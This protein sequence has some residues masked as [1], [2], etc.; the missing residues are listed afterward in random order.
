MP[1]LNWNE[2]KRRAIVFAGNWA[3]ATRER[4]DAQTFWNE[5]FDCFGIRRASVASFE[6]PIRNLGGHTDFIDL[7]WKGKLLA[8]HKSRGK[9]LDRAQSQAND[10]IQSLQREGHGDEVPR[11]LV[12]SD[13]ARVALTDL[14]PPPGKR[15]AFVEFDLKDFPKHVRDFSFLIDIATVDDAPEDDANFQ[16]TRMMATLH[17]ALQDG[18]YAGHDLERLLVRILFC[19]FADDTGIFADDPAAKPF[20]HYIRTH[21]REDGSDLGPQ[22]LRL[23]EV[24]DHPREKRQANLDEDLAR[25]PHVNGQLFAERLS[26]ADFTKP[27]RDTLL[28]C[29]HFDWSKISPAV[30][31]SLFQDV[32]KPRDRRQLGAHYTSER[33]ILKL[34]RSLFLDDLRTELEHLQGLQRDRAKRLHEFQDK[35]RGLTFLD[36]ACGCGNFLVIAYR[37]LRLLELDALKTL[38]VDEPQ[39]LLV[40]SDLVRVNVDQFYGIEIEEWPARIAEVAMWLMDHQMNT[41]VADE[42]ALPL[43]RLPLVASATVRHDNALRVDWGAVLPADRCSYVMGNPPFVGKKEQN[44]AQKAD[45]AHVWGDASGAGVLDLVTCWYLLASRYCRARRVRFAFV[46]TNSICQGEQVGILWRDLISRGGLEITFAH[47]TFAW[48]S[49][50]RGQAHVHVVIIGLAGAGTYAGVRQLY[51][52]RD[53]AEPIVTVVPQISCY[54]TA[55]TSP[56]IVNRQTPLN[57]PAALSYGSFALDDGQYTLTPDDRHQIVAESPPAAMFIH[58]FVGARELLHG[59]DRY[60][61]WLADAAPSEIRALPPVMRRV[62][63]VKQWRQSRGRA[64][65]VGLAETPAIFAEMRQP[66]TQYV[67]I[68]TVSSERRSYIPMDFLSPQVVASNQIYVLAGA[69]LF[70]FGVLTS[71]MHMAWVR[72]VCGRLKS[73]YR[74]SSKLVYNN[75]PWPP[76]ATAAQ[77]QAVEAA[78]QGVLDARSAFPGQTLADLY[79][80]LAMPKALR[81]AHRALDRAVDRCYRPEKFDTDR[82]RVEFLFG[83]YEKLTTLFPAPATRPAKGRRKGWAGGD[84]PA[85]A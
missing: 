74:Y 62:E 15:T 45:F 85:V 58:R 8:E 6:V 66:A 60:C 42:F 20:E 5:F 84:G 68:P 64:T 16:A 76:D 12:V 22:L 44:A 3:K 49:E 30:F 47:T 34:I 28:A 35:L 78:A 10:Y 2:I 41:L 19:L 1:Q 75:Y 27:M 37:E 83:L 23:F 7:F 4:S 53:D 69:G 40:L 25:L 39:R 21:T 72:Q 71:V 59:E 56:F 82:Q 65:T 63:A 38:R 51:E 52:H 33:D 61:L 13:F 54:L 67:A 24:L 57:A 31:G 55:G 50:A 32:M 70:H 43:L 77:R 18:G 9:P 29:C 14:E 17:D 79:D 36:P 81:D 11:W 46:S 48:A 80:P 73:D 26:F